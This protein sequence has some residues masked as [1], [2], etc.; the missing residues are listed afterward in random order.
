[1]TW[2]FAL[3]INGKRYT[4]LED[5]PPEYRALLEQGVVGAVLKRDASGWVE[6]IATHGTGVHRQREVRI[7]SRGWTEVGAIPEEVVASLRAQGIDLKAWLSSQTPGPAGEPMEVPL[8][9]LLQA[10]KAAPAAP[11]TARPREG[12]RSSKNI[13]T[14]AKG[15]TGG[16]GLWVALAAVVAIA[17]IAWLV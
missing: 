7:G 9:A 17:L 16:P 8:H 15:D 4:R 6:Q 10:A 3:E 1:M 14:V 11:A 5:V 13:H 12:A 2:P